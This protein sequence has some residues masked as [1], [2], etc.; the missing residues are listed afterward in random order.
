MA[1]IQKINLKSGKASYRVFKRLGNKKPITKTFKS[2]KAA[3]EYARRVEGDKDLAR[4]LGSPVIG[5]L[6]LEAII[7][8]YEQQFTGK[9]PNTIRRLAW[10]RRNFG[11]QLLVDVS[12]VTIRQGLN[13]LK[14]AG[15]QGGT[16]NRYKSCLSSVFQLAK[17]NH[18]ISGNPC[19]EVKAKPENKG[20]V[21]FLSD[22]EREALLTGCR[23]SCWERLYLI[24]FPH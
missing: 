8:E 1:T 14:A 11:D 7:D 16:L 5:S 21:R 20:R 18:G 3:S 10:W 12:H 2:K 23:S 24:Y 13:Q 15:R 6:K 19:R 4:A 9:D 22:G 17:E